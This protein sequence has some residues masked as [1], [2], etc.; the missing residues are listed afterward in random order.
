MSKKLRPESVQ[1]N[2]EKRKPT[3]EIPA[4][5]QNLGTFWNMTVEFT[6]EN[7][8]EEN[9]K[10]KATASYIY[11]NISCIHTGVMHDGDEGFQK[12]KGRIDSEQEQIEEDQSDPVDTTDSVKY[13]RPSSENKIE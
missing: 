6:D 5:S 7:Q 2:M 11:T 4:A 13:N 12:C 9:G 10:K 3:T 1:Y 8:G